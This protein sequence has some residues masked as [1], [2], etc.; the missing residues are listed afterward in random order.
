MLWLLHCINGL[1][2]VVYRMSIFTIKYTAHFRT[3]YFI[4]LFYWNLW[5][6]KCSKCKSNQLTTLTELYMF[7]FWI[8]NKFILKQ[9][10]GI[11]EIPCWKYMMYGIKANTK[12]KQMLVGWIVV[13]ELLLPMNTLIISLWNS[14]EK[15]MSSSCTI[16]KLWRCFQSRG[17]SLYEKD[18]KKSKDPATYI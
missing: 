4:Y 18:T 16:L 5:C 8:S 15:V 9:N 11:T 12:V 17:S 3:K 7:I 13:I 1:G 6:K 10:I 2:L 14:L